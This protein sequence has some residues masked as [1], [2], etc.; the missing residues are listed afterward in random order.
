VI[1]VCIDFKSPQAYLA[2]APTRA[3]EA[4]L[5]IAFD[6]RPLIV[7]ALPKH[8][9]SAN[10]DRGARHKR[11][12]AEY[13]ARDLERYAAA[14]GL[15]L[16]DPYRNP[17]T[18]AASLGL[19]WLRRKSP[20][21]AAGYVERM[22]ERLWQEDANI[23]DPALVEAE[24]GSLADGFAR[25]AQGEGPEELSRSQRELLEAGAWN[26]PAYLAFGEVFI[27]RAHLPRLEWLARHSQSSTGTGTTTV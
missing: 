1:T 6:W 5:G 18:T 12:R 9:P 10:E 8:E 25:Y 26:A 7:P 16:S 27:G 23:A 20:E 13:L 15:R 11:M 19:L 22:F 2:I 21:A 14:R 17:D 24:L 3:L 4:K